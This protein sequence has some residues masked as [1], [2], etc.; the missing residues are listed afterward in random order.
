LRVIR[1]RISCLVLIRHGEYSFFVS[2]GKTFW[3]IPKLP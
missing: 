1:R 2:D 3:M